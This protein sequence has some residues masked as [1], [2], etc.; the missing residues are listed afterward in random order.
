LNN[1]INCIY[2]KECS[3]PLCPLISDRLNHELNW[4]PDEEVCRRVKN[5]PRWVKQQRKV[6]LKCKPE[7]FGYYFTPEMLKVPFR[8][9]KCVQGIDPNKPDTVKRLKAWH[10]RFKGTKSR[11]LSAEQREQKRA[12]IKLVRK[13]NQKANKVKKKLAA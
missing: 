5:I 2:Y 8:V 9:T 6:A 3:A 4:Y 10:K 11:K 1:K 13:S 12:N 7:N